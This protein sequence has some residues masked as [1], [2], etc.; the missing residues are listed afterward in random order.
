M[1]VHLGRRRGLPPGHARRTRPSSCATRRARRRARRA[2]GVAVRPNHDEAPEGVRAAY[3]DDPFGNRIELIAGRLNGGEGAGRGTASGEER[4]APAGAVSDRAAPAGG[5]RWRSGGLRGP[6]GGLPRSSVRP[7]E[8]GE[9][10]WRLR[11]KREERRH[12]GRAGSDPSGARLAT[13]RVRA[14]AGQDHAGPARRVVL[15]QRSVPPSAL[16]TWATM[17]RPRPEPGSPRAAGTGRSG[18]RRGGGPL[19]DARSVVVH[20][21]RPRRG[22]RLRPTRPG[23]APLPG[24][25]EQVAHR[26]AQP[27]GVAHDPAGLGVEVEA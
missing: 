23:G 1:A 19:G 26:P 9:T 14:R 5:D 7:C 10:G 27:V 20:D 13:R 2:A 21:D 18:R 22:I 6:P 16:T 8:L 24:V 4:E 11:K 17:A 15:G 25:V 12:R 3:V